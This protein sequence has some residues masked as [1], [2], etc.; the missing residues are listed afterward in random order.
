MEK[1]LGR[2][3]QKPAEKVSASTASNETAG[4]LK[5]AWLFLE[6]GEFDSAKEYVER[7]LDRDPETGEAYWVK[8]LAGLGVR[9]ETDLKERHQTLAGEVNYQKA[10]RFGT[11]ELKRRLEGFE[12][13]I[14][15]RTADIQR[16]NAERAHRVDFFGDGHRADLGGVC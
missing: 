1:V 9:R 13:D 12:A 3:R 2:D 7:V 15:R 4:W 14:Q 8:C 5:R 10:L 16:R 11:P 6:D